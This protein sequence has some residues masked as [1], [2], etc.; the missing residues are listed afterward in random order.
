M[1]RACSACGGDYEDP[2]RTAATDPEDD[3]IADDQEAIASELA[4]DGEDERGGEAD[5]RT[6]RAHAAEDLDPLAD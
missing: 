6:I 4:A 1:I 3:T 2:E 5:K